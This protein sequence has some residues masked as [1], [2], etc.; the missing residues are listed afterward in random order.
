M[1]VT[2]VETQNDCSGLSLGDRKNYIGASECAALFGRT[3]YLT[4]WQLWMLKSGKLE[5]EDLSEKESV[6]WGSL[7]E[8]TIA[9]GVE[10]K[11]GWTL[12]KS[13][14]CYHPEVEG[15]ACHP[16]YD[17]ISCDQDETSPATNGHC[18]GLL[19]IK[20]LDSFHY[21]KTNG[22]L[23]FRYYIQLQTQLYCRGLSWG[24]LGVLVGGNNLVTKE[25]EADF[26]LWT[27]IKEN[28]QAFWR[29]VEKGIEP[30]RDFDRDAAT[31]L[32]WQPLDPN[33]YVQQTDDSVVIDLCK[34]RIALRGIKSKSEDTLKSVQAQVV[35]TMGASPQLNVNGEYQVNRSETKN[36]I[37]RL[38]IK[39]LKKEGDD[40]VLE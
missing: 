31:I 9:R 2:Q 37:K 18:V 28:V 30:S 27:A 15:L 40:N 8:P 39:Q 38:S 33:A 5:P 13:S 11:T 26:V 12:K 25:Y 35:S 10:L 34:K 20:T 22:C 32:R 36:G 14:G 19:E 17:I 4:L 16:D 29:S 24:V 1:N 6:F 21:W 3:P 23:P 7:L